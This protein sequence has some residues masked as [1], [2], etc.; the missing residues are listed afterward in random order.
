MNYSWS[1]PHVDTATFEDTETKWITTVVM[2]LIT[3]DEAGREHTIQETIT[4]PKPDP[5]SSTFVAT[6]NVTE[7][8]ALQW[9]QAEMMKQAMER[10]GSIELQKKMNTTG[11]NLPWAH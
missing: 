9:G 11:E 6:E 2:K 1:V 10:A 4:L 3:R 8:L 7:A 5:D